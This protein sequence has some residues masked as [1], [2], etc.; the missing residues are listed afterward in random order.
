M[1]SG[2]NQLVLVS[3]EAGTGKTALVQDMREPIVHRGG[4]FVSGKFERFRHDVPY[5]ALAQA[6][7]MLIR[8]V[9]HRD[10]E[11]RAALG[12]QLAEALG[13]N[14]RVLVEVIPELTELLGEVPPVIALPPRAA[15]HRFHR[16]F[17][18][19]SRF[20]ARA[21]HPLVLF[22]DDMH[23]AD[24]AS[25]RL[26]HHLISD[27]DSEH[28]LVIGT[29]RSSA[30][31][32]TSPL[33]T[34]IEEWRVGDA[35][36]SEIAMGALTRVDVG[37]MVCDTL[38]SP[39]SAP[40]VSIYA[41]IEELVGLVYDKTKGN[42]L[43]IIQLLETLH[44]DGLLY[45]EA[46]EDAWRWSGARIRSSGHC[47]RDVVALMSQRLAAVPED[48]QRALRHAACL[49][50][51]FELSLLA[52]A[53][54]ESLREVA[55]HL[56]LALQ[57]G[58]VLPLDDR[59]R[60]PILLEAEDL[61]GRGAGETSLGVL[62]IRYR[63][64]H[65]C[66][67]RAAYYLYEEPGE[68]ALHLAIGQRLLRELP[69]AAR[70]EHL[71]VISSQ[72]D[73]GRKLL[74]DLEMREEVAEFDLR[75]ARRAR[76]VGA[77][78]IGL[79]YTGA[80]MELLGDGS[81]MHHHSL[82][83]D[84]HIEALS[85]AQAVGNFDR[86]H[87]LAQMA[88][89]Y[90]DGPLEQATLNAHQIEILIGQGK[91]QEAIEIALHALQL[92][93]VPLRLDP[94]ESFTPELLSAKLAESG[95]TGAILAPARALADRILAAAWLTYG[96]LGHETAGPVLYT[97]LH[98]CAEG[99]T[100]RMV[101]DAAAQFAVLLCGPLNDIERGYEF[102]RLSL[103]L[104]ER[105]SL[106]EARPA[107]VK[108]F[109][110]RVH[111][112]RAPLRESI[113][114]LRL[115]IRQ[116]L[117]HGDPTAAGRAAHD[118][119]SHLL[120]I[121]EH[122]ASVDEQCLRHSEL[123]DKLGLGEHVALFDLAHHLLQG[124]LGD[125][126]TGA[127]D[128]PAV[129][130]RN[131][132]RAASEAFAEVSSVEL[133]Y[134]GNVLEAMYAYIFGDIG[135]AL[136]CAER[137]SSHAAGA[138]SRFLVAEHNCFLS[139]IL[140]AHCERLDG[141]ERQPFLHRVAANQA[142][143]SIW[144]HHA[145]ENFQFRFDLVAAEQARLTRN[146]EEAIALF[147]R[148]VRGAH[149]HAA[150][151]F[152]AMGLERRATLHGLRGETQIAEDLLRDA[153]AVYLRWGARA[154]AQQIAD[155][156]LF[157]IGEQWNPTPTVV[158]EPDLTVPHVL[159]L[160]VGQDVAEQQLVEPDLAGLLSAS[161]AISRE[162]E[163]ENLLVRVVEALVEH[164]GAPRGLIA[165][166]QDSRLTVEAYWAE[167]DVHVQPGPAIHAVDVDS[168]RVW[169]ELLSEVMETRARLH[170]N[171]V[172][173]DA[174]FRGHS[175]VTAYGPQS[176]LALPL[177][178]GDEFYGVVYLEDDT[179]RSAFSM[180]RVEAA[181]MLAAQ[182]SISLGNTRSVLGRLS[183]AEERMK[184]EREAQN[185]ALAKEAWALAKLNV[186]K[187]KFLSLMAH[188]LKNALNQIVGMT[189]VMLD[190]ID[191][192]EPEEFEPEEFRGML[193]KLG[194]T[195]EGCTDLLINL[196][197]WS[198][199]QSGGMALKPERRDLR[200]LAE[201]TVKLLDH[202]AARKAIKLENK[203]PRESWILADPNMIDTIVRNLVGNSL[204]FT[205]RE[206]RVTIS[207]Q[208][209]RPPSAGGEPPRLEM[210]NV[211]ITDTGIG[212]KPEDLG[213]LFRTDVHHT[214]KGTANEKG[215]GFGLTMCQ[216]MVKQ[217]GG[218]IWVESEVGKGTTFRFTVPC[219]PAE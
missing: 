80:A 37:Q 3:G 153:H 66:A 180:D 45:Y 95:Q 31:S 137:A 201:K 133:V 82:T 89:R 205:P 166:W 72:L 109:Y 83:L 210:L 101:A 91:A 78:E 75:A 183:E 90:A 209:H 110:S 218:D 58:L 24:A 206:G 52:A 199:L 156:P 152:E 127:T 188:D 38:L 139:L 68:A 16:A 22:L 2:K 212:I 117:D 162:I 61:E 96:V 76:R 59:Y 182:M 48:A 71:F 144:A 102:G 81:W 130:A 154:K 135:R 30:L 84:L 171:D 57:T 165:L 64:A 99:A 134:A 14:G 26:V 115:S 113:A 140:L 88:L 151:H 50:A 141:L 175:Y 132:A 214:T 160:I 193:E 155:D 47:E 136:A 145:P 189:D 11:S 107:A 174:R 54:G 87:K 197:T 70:N 21:E 116:G 5:S 161:Q 85:D 207:A 190:E 44:A 46:E 28:L 138:M 128:D 142:Q 181:R 202:T 191:E 39:G 13:S 41:R 143:M 74:D 157:D 146:D 65:D 94:P 131:L 10:A 9:R 169:P 63:F 19:L 215:S 114:P 200:S 17:R 108:T 177:I 194:Q 36:V 15:L 60:L 119:C 97:R 4:C 112:W 187:E 167:G 216:E 129:T 122:L 121:G 118:Y 217:N 56:W 196:L 198:R 100:P 208:P 53:T 195:A 126:V 92:L 86:A 69:E 77:H 163:P 34:S 79:A 27:P 103:D 164:T 184:R 150:L 55:A 173:A 213:K 104:V 149:E 211:S 25:L 51:S 111:H 204:K 124:L 20:F 105:Y 12:T 106:E 219:A 67:Q 125:D 73:F 172:S 185:E 186:D 179:R 32:A 159:P 23:W 192:I 6:F 123:A 42:P 1:S 203:V 29:Y 40:S 176:V 62:E 8:Q 147:D 178:D 35:E 43:H 33:A 168:E 148:A 93:D 98:L 120:F 170:L 18:L 7:R 49:G 158:D